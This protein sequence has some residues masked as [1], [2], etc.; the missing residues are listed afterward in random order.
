MQEN[1]VVRDADGTM[2]AA[3]P[4]FYPTTVA[5]IAAFDPPTVLSLLDAL[6]EADARRDALNDDRAALLA[7]AMTVSAER[8]RLAEALAVAREALEKDASHAAGCAYMI[9]RERGAPGG[10]PACNCWKSNAL[11]RIDAAVEL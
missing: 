7:D 3:T 5:H 2:V 9:A 8:D 11:A 1:Y 10:W 6:D 4:E